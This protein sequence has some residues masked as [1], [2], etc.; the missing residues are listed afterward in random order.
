[1]ASKRRMGQGT[2]TCSIIRHESEI[3]QEESNNMPAK[4]SLPG[5]EVYFKPHTGQVIIRKIGV[6][7]KSEAVKTQNIRFAT[8]MK[9]KKIATACKQPENM[10]PGKKYRAFKACLFTEGKKAFGRA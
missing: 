10:P 4:L 6:D 3:K 1:M 7:R 5:T 8:A 9:G 2:Y